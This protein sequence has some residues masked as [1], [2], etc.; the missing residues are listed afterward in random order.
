VRKL[1]NTL[2]FPTGYRIERIARF[3]RELHHLVRTRPR[4]L[5]FVQI[6]ANDGVRFD[7]L[8]G[9]VTTHSCCGVVVE[10][11]P[12]M[13]ERLRANYADYPQIVP[14]NKAIHETATTMP[15][16]RVA[17]AALA[18]YEGWA[19]GISSFDREHLLRHGIAPQDLIAQQVDCIPL[20]KL[21][22]ETAALDADILQ[23]DTEGYDSA[24][25]QMIDLA[26]FRPHLIKYE[27]KAMT[28]AQRAA[29]TRTFAQYGYRCV[30]E[31]S[32]T[33][34]WNGRSQGL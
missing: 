16:F 12:D 25:L 26:R 32:D 34:A 15:L 2:L 19:T 24:I 33:T 31:G 5:K 28:A 29:H 3:Q 7:G 9:F 6:G 18:R 20:M 17:P 10:P 8:Y 23:I 27:H 13:F 30:S 11:L 22:E 14:I 21:L 4:R 1:L